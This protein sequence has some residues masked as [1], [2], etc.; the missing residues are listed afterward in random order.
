MQ[1]LDFELIRQPATDSL[2]FVSN[3]KKSLLVAYIAGEER[4]QFLFNILRAAGYTNPKE[5]LYLLPLGPGEESQDLSTICRQYQI[6][7]VLI[8]GLNPKHLG[9]HLRLGNYVPVQVNQ[10]AFMYGHDLAI[11]K[12]EKEDG[13]PQKAGALWQA[14]KSNFMFK[15]A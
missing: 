12:A 10:C 8:F 9:L 14:I 6:D 7:Q 2:P 15:S 13:K 4:E 11:I 1:Y 5:E 3:A